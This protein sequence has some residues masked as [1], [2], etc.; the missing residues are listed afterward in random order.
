MTVFNFEKFT[1]NYAMLSAQKAEIEDKMK[2]LKTRLSE[3]VS[4]LEDRKSTTKYATLYFKKASTRETAD[5][6]AMKVNDP[7]LYDLLMNKGYIKVTAVEESFDIKLKPV[8]LE[9]T[10]VV[11]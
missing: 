10:T 6:K 5:L 3:E 9:K 7:D 8:L 1:K 11:K 4:K 2:K